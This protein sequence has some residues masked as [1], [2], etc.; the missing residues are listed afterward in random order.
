LLTRSTSNF[1]IR[2]LVLGACV[3]NVFVVPADAARA[4]ALLQEEALHR[5][6]QTASISMRDSAFQGLLKH[7]NRSYRGHRVRRQGWVLEASAHPTKSDVIIVHVSARS[8]IPGTSWTAYLRESYGL[9][10]GD[11]LIWEGVVQDIDAAGHIRLGHERIIRWTPRD[12]ARF[13][14][15]VPA[16]QG[17]ERPEDWRP[18]GLAGRPL[19]RRIEP[20][21]PSAAFEDYVSADVGLRIWVSPIGHVARASV[22]RSSGRGEIDQAAIDAV[23]AWRYAPWPGG[24]AHDQVE[25]VWVRVSAR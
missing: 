16:W 22:L 3:W 11:H 5:K 20:V 24:P 12:H 4:K 7:L 2:R 9:A 8:D 10:P 19:L 23:R 14:D 17:Y 6:I 25:D 21:V 1:L 18:Q 13:S 15:D